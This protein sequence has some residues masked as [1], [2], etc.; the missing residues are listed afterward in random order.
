LSCPKCG[1]K[2]EPDDRFCPN[3]GSP[4][5]VQEAAPA[6]EAEHVQYM[7]DR[8]SEHRFAKG[9]AKSYELFFTN[10]RIIVARVGGGARRV[11][12]RGALGGIVGTLVESRLSAKTAEKLKRLNVQEII[13]S[14]PDN[15]VIPYETIQMVK[16][17]KPGLTRPIGMEIVT[18]METY[19]FDL[20]RKKEFENYVHSLRQILGNKLVVS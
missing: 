3:C 18:P 2:L 9:L 8:V 13:S 6:E 7:I 15:I 11:L 16:M 1:A 4:V 5:T 20:E 19:K 12:F 14:N 17:K 10:K